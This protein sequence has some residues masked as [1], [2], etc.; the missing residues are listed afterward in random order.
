MASLDEIERFLNIDTDDKILHEGKRREDKNR[1]FRYRGQYY[2]VKLTQNKWTILDDSDTTRDLLE[3]HVFCCGVN[4]YVTTNINRKTTYIHRLIT[5]CDGDNVPDH[6]NR[7]SFD[8]RLANLCEGT[9]KDN[10][11]N[12]S[13]ASN[14]ISGKQGV[15]RFR[16]GKYHYYASCI[17]NDNGEREQKRFSIAKLGEAEAKR[18]AIEHRRAAEIL[19][20]YLGE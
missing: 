13:T 11:R 4:D 16:T 14:N 15:F 3:D 6:I 1:Y 12:R 19:Y 8:N 17:T 10:T 7:K 18:R 5:D 2:I 9:Q 20:G